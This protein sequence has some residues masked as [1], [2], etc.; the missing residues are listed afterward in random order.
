M[1]TL[2]QGCIFLSGFLILISLAACDLFGSSGSSG[3]PEISTPEPNSF[4]LSAQA[5]AAASSSFIFTNSGDANLSFNLS[6]NQAWLTLSPTSGTVEASESQTVNLTANCANAELGSN[7]ASITLTSNDADEKTKT[8]TANLNCTAVGNSN[9][10][11]QLQY[12]GSG[13]NTARQAVF[14]AAANRWAEV[15]IEDLSDV[16]VPAGQQGIPAN[17]AC[18]FAHDAFVGTIDD[19][20]IF[21]SISPIDGE[22]GILGQ[23]GP[24]LI[25]SNGKTTVGC[26]QFD[27]ADVASLEAADSLNNVILHEMGH[28]L[29]IGTLWSLTLSDGTV[30]NDLL[31][32][33]ANGARCA[34]ASSF[35]GLPVFTGSDTKTEYSALGQTGDVPV[36]NE[37]GPGT[38]CG[39]W[40][41]GI[42]DTELMTGF[43]EAA[44]VSMPLSRLTIASLKDMN[45][46]VSFASAD[47]YAIPSCSPDC[48]ARLQS[49]KSFEKWEVVLTPKGI[50]NEN[51]E[52]NW[53]NP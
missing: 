27:S 5:N 1:T 44:N 37:F 20:L 22:G 6:S 46:E 47:N 12:S 21:A 24:A 39:H 31:D 40:D 29:G 25:R 50:V 16:E 17:R 19:L 41:E 13:F 51:G 48:T 52:I 32:F 33:E 10:S 4:N 26:M 30:I 49:P 35:T 8:L 3:S 7:T 15:I 28:V 23:A 34:E 45:Y 9:Y 36:E 11:I 14:E 53:L 43:A 42:F 38:Q 18:S 2:R